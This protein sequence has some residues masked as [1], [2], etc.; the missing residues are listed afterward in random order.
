MTAYADI[1]Q[2]AA[3]R[4]WW[5]QQALVRLAS[6]T[7]FTEADYEELADALVKPEPR[8]PSGGW[9]TGIQQPAETSSPPVTLTCIR[10]VSNVNRLATGETLTFAPT[11]V[12][13]VYGNNGSGKSGYARLVKALVHTRHQE[14]VLPDIFSTGGGAQAA[15]LEYVWNGGTHTVSVRCW[16]DA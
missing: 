5:Q 1:V 6:G 15:C 8:A 7:P 4:P 13:V 3:S 11:G 12:T 9:L 10:D 16:T 14:M 2:W